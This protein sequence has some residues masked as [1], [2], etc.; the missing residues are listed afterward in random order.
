MQHRD[1]G[2]FD[3]TKFHEMLHVT[4]HINSLDFGSLENVLWSFK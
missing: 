2:N 3:T 4:L 1:Y